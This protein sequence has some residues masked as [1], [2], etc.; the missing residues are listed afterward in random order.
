[1]TLVL[2]QRALAAALAALTAVGWAFSLGMAAHAHHGADL[3]A[4]FAMWAAMM[5]G[6][7]IPPEAPA[8]LVL[9]R[10][11]GS[12]AD[13]GAWLA[14][15]LA[16]WVLFSLGAAGLQLWL[17]ERGLMD[18]AMAT[19]SSALAGALLVAAGA[20]QLSPLKRACLERCRAAPAAGQPFLGG[21]RASALSIASCG[22]LMLVLFATGVMSVPAMAVLTLLLLLE[23]WLPRGAPVSA[24]TGAL[25]V[26]W[27]LWKL[28]GA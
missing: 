21:L 25:L 10:A 22:L 28:V 7:M 4:L 23:R 3:A 14:G 16:P 15:F 17:A 2:E 24:A 1:V 18:H 11:R 27:G 13:A 26:L 9:A 5:V 20:V 12:A 19:S 8:L 6:M